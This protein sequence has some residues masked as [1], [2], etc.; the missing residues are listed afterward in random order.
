MGGRKKTGR[1]P[2]TR[3]ML[4]ACEPEI[5][6]AVARGDTISS[7]AEQA[8]CSTH[9]MCDWLKRRE[10]WARVRGLVVS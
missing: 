9:A 7:M 10:L 6:E 8:G 4:D 3:R 2:T 1:P 5:R